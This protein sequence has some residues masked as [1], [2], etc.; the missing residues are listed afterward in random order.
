MFKENLADLKAYNPGPSI[1]E[2]KRTYGLKRLV[3]LDSNENVYG[4]SPKV[5]EAI[6]RAALLPALYPDC[7]DQD[8]RSEL[9]Q[10]LGVPE[11]QFLFGC[12]LDE[13]IVLI[14]RAFLAPGDNIVMA[15]PTF[16]EY[17]CH[18]QIEGAETRKIP[19]DAN[20]KHDLGAMLAATDEATRIVWICNPNNP[21]GTYIN[22]REL[23]DFVEKAADDAVIVLDEAYIDFVAAEDF[24]RSLDLL[25]KHPNIV[26]LRTFSKSYGLASF[27]IGYAIGQTQLINEIDKVRPPFN[28]PRLSQIAAFAALQDI[29][30]MEDCVRKNREVLAMTAAFLGQRKI[31]Y[32][33]TQTN[34]IYVKADDPKSVAEQCR[35]K[36]FLINPFQ[37]GVRITIGKMEDMKELLAVLETAL[38]GTT[39]EPSI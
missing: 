18:A 24:P 23:T 34:F 25:K 20:G 32:Y 36:G 27:R 2:I 6:A 4:A 1:E 3:K 39:T 9:S 15:W 29:D 37:D 14:S 8:V 16:Y 5:G 22:E 30:F 19:C 33:P 38:S 13:I 21:T 10:K 26:V 35:K 11:E 28:N 7:K 17:Y 31:P 12:G